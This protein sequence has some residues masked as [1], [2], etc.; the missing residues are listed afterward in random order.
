MEKILSQDEI[1]A[2]FSSMSSES[3]AL[4][5]SDSKPAEV[6]RKIARYDFCRSDRIGKDQVRALHQLHSNFARNYSS[7]LSAYMRS[8]VE[9][10][11]IAIDQISYS[12]FLKLMSDPTLFCALS[13]APIHGNFGMELSPPLVFPLIDMLLGGTGKPSVE[14]RPLTDLEIQIIEGVLKLALRDLKECWRP[15]LDLNLQLAGVEVKPQ[16]L[17]LVPLS[18]PVVAIGFEVKSGDISGM[19]N[20]CIPSVILKTNRSVFEAYRRPRSSGLEASETTKISQ[21]VR[22]ARV[23]L[24]SQIRDQVL[25]VEDLL[26]ISVG[27]VIQLN[28][29][30]GDSVQLSVAGIPKF[31]GQI[32]MKRGKRALQISNKIVV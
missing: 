7:S 23:M 26:N 28:H 31:A 21:A 18:E 2:L 14:N 29:P 6:E 17:Q 15:V 30:I 8:L 19:L 4:K 20:L 10:N 16:M 1:N 22:N 12:E 3:D 27:D 13:L 11:L 24:S 9:I 5:G 25:A 32:V